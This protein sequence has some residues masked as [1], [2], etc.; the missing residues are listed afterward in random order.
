MKVFNLCCYLFEMKYGAI[1]CIH[2]YR[3]SARKFLLYSINQVE[4]TINKN[5]YVL[6]ILS[7]T[8][9]SYRY[10]SSVSQF[11]FFF[12]LRFNRLSHFITRIRQLLDHNSI[13]RLSSLLWLSSWMINRN[14]SYFRFSLPPLYPSIK[15][16]VSFYRASFSCLTNRQ[17]IALPSFFSSKFFPRINFL[18]LPAS[19]KLNGNM[20]LYYIRYYTNYRGSYLISLFISSIYRSKK[21]LQTGKWI[22]YFEIML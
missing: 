14:L 4:E 3:Q 2:F 8:E 20:K 6:L 17:S 15:G 10:F 22:N 13:T 7:L 11:F 12:F 16:D 19:I 18:I 5:N 1:G 21:V 9:N